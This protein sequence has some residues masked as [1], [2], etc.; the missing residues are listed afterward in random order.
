MARLIQQLDR[1]RP[2]ATWVG[3]LAPITIGDHGAEVS[4]S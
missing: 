4:G 2:P 3:N 1:Y